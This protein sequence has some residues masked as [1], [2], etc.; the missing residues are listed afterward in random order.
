MATTVP[1]LANS[2]IFNARVDDSQPILSLSSNDA[3]HFEI[4]G[5]LQQAVN[6]GADIAPVLEVAKNIIPGDWE[7]FTQNWF[8]L[9]NDTKFRALDEG[10]AYDP[11]NVRTSWFSVSNYFRRADVYNRVDW[12]D[13]RINEYW[14]EQRSAF[15]K[16]I[17]TLQFPA[18]RIQIPADEFVVE[19]I[20]YPCSNITEP[21]PTL[22]LGNG[23]DAAQED[24]YANIVA[25]A[26]ARGYNVI[27]YEGPGQPTVR[28]EQ[29]LGFIHDWERVLT[30]VVDYVLSVK[31]AEV[32]ADRLVLYGSSFGGYLDARAAAFEPRLTA[33]M[34]N[35]GVWDMFDAYTTH[36]PPEA[37]D[38]YRDGDRDGFDKVV[39]AYKTDPEMDTTV[40]WGVLQG[41]WAF[42]LTSPYDFVD[43]MKLFT[44]KGGVTDTIQMPAWIADAE[45]EHAM[46]GQSQLVKDALGDWAELHVF[47]GSAGYHCQVGASQELNRVMFAWLDK[48][49]YPGED[50]RAGK[51]LS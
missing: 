16:A 22:I 48:I 35:G 34:L 49:L 50:A 3:F 29:G 30:P 9:A 38:M 36:L 10:I 40:R 28:R 5:G 14:D 24:F 41:M 17:A 26:T 1:A 31:A 7:S 37:L 6:D 46:V 47:R 12:D 43:A 2:R 44:L 15:D 13:P 4:L 42:N 23:Y 27:S 51:P 21:R 20:W 32:D 8:E 39:N 45:H 25:P 33:L 18:E 11:V 19:A